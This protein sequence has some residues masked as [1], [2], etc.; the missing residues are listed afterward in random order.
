MI[1]VILCSSNIWIVDGNSCYFIND[2]YIFSWSE[3]DDRTRVSGFV[4]AERGH[5]WRKD[6]L[7]F[8]TVFTSHAYYHSICNIA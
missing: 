7:Y 6:E 4:E 2:R 8:F 1:S 3:F 5:R